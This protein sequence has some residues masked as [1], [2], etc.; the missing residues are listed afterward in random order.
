MVTVACLC[1]PRADGTPRHP[2]GDE[3]Q[4]RERLDFRSATT[5]RNAVGFARAED[6]ELSGAEILAILTEHYI[7]FGIEGWTV[8]DADGKPLPVTKPNLRSLLLTN[9]E[10]AQVV[11][12]AADERYGEQILG[13]LVRAAS[14]SSPL[15]PTN[16]S[17]SASKDSPSSNPTPSSP[18]STTTIPTAGTGTITSLPAGGSRSSRKSG[19]AA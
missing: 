11:A 9:D 14:T 10:A 6:P 13:P 1:P 3:V 4:L 7:L 16:D 8:A 2:D 17:T 15:T 5:I 12:D 19:T 18:S